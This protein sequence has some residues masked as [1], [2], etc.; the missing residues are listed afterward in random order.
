MFG[1]ELYSSSASSYIT[2]W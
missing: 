2:W 1:G